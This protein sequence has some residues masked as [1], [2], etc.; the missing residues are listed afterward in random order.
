MFLATGTCGCVKRNEKSG[1]GPMRTIHDGER[2]GIEYGSSMRAI[3][4]RI[5]E[6]RA[7]EMHKAKAKG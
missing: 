2:L 3:L 4:E 1:D 7:R 6:A 5:G